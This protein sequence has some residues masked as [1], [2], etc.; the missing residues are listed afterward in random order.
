MDSNFLKGIDAA[1]H[2]LII[3][4]CVSVPLGIW[5]LVDIALW[6][7]GHFEITAK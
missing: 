6:I 3:V 5:K 2:A 1:I 7:F 4:L